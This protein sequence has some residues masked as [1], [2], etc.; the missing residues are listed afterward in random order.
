LTAAHTQALGF[1]IGDALA[2]TTSLSTIA[3]ALAGATMWSSWS[4]SRL[5]QSRARMQLSA[6]Q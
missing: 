1:L 5:A 6:V 2:A 3:L 4:L